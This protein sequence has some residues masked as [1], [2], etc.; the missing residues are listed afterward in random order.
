MFLFSIIFTAALLAQ[1]G[2]SSLHGQVSDPSGAV[3]IKAKIT[4]KGEKGVT[5]SAVT[6]SK[7]SYEIKGLKPGK[8]TLQISAEGFSQETQEVEL[9]AGAAQTKDISLSIQ[10]QQQAV[11]VEEDAQ[12]VSVDPSSNASAI[13]LKGSDL[14]ALSDDPDDLLSDLQALAGPAA[15]PDGGEVYIDGFSNGQLPPKSSIR[16]VRINQNFVSAQYDRAGMGRIEVFTKPGSDKYHGFFMTGV[17]HSVFNSLNSYLNK[18]RNELPDYHTLFMNGNFGGPLGKKASFFFS[19]QRRSMDNSSVYNASVPCA[20]PG[21]LLNCTVNSS[22]AVSS[23]R[24][25]TEIAPR[26]DYQLTSSNSLMFRYEY[27]TNN[28]KNQGVSTFSLPSQATDSE[29]YD[30][31]FYISDT[32]IIN[33]TMVNES[34]LFIRKSHSENTI[35]TPGRTISVANYFTNGGNSSADSHSDQQSIEFQNYTSK[36][37]GKHTIKF[38]GRLRRSNLDGY[39]RGNLLGSISYANLGAYY[40]NAWQYVSIDRGNPN[41][42]VEQ[43]DAGLYAE[44]DWRVLPKLTLSYG[45]RFETQENVP[46]KVNLA[47]RV[48]VSWNVAPKTVLRAGVGLFYDR[49][50]SNN[51]QNILRYNNNGPLM[52]TYSLWNDLNT[53]S[54]V[55]PDFNSLPAASVATYHNLDPNFKIPYT[56]QVIVSLERQLSRSATISVGYTGTRGLHQLVTENLMAFQHATEYQYMSAGTFKQNQLTVSPRV[57]LN[58]FLS[59]NGWYVYGHANGNANGNPSDPLQGDLLNLAADWGRSRFDIRHRGMFGGTISL[60]HGLRLNPMVTM[61]TG[62]PYSIQVGQDINGDSI[63]NDRPWY[64]NACTATPVKAGI[65]STSL[66]CFSTIAGDPGNLGRV[67]INSMTGPGTTNVN[68]R[69]SKTFGLG[70]QERAQNGGPGSRGGSGGPGGGR[71]PGGHGGFMG[72]MMGGGGGTGQKYN[73]TF[74]VQASN[75]L[76]TFKRGIPVNTLTSANFGEPKT[77]GGGGMGFG[78]GSGPNRSFMFNMMFNF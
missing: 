70:K 32:Q 58:K 76:N 42:G 9:A 47:P 4:A 59:L 15:G 48:G 40:Q 60:P 57:T 72:G 25:G 51:V 64:S 7:G 63:N 66:G 35:L 69:L 62:A 1:T 45:L 14:D 36:M 2:T 53:P 38:G 17:N 39:S 54:T 18:P 30:H 12:A 49:F 27:E 20:D 11:T 34:R 5:A 71:G 44:D 74:S 73:L 41:Y 50:R 78:G 31:S 68:L 65:Y 75:L 55:V 6:D 29:G 37:S 67:P 16:E 61:Q 28:S 24:A 26:L 33:T 43:T 52:M 21:A 3:V 10:V 46:N 13:V 56:E 22:G 8:Y 23:P 77:N 19:V